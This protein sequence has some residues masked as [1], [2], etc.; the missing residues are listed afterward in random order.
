MTILP[1]ISLLEWGERLAN[2]VIRFAAPNYPGVLNGQTS[3]SLI[4]YRRD[5]CTIFDPRVAVPNND[6]RLNLIH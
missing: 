2:D 4:Y 5:G 6:V 3:L 1:K